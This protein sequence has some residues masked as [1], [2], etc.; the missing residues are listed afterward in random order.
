MKVTVSASGHPAANN[1]RVRCLSIDAAEAQQG[2]GEGIR[3]TFETIA[4]DTKGTKSYRTIS[5][6]ITPSNAAGQFVAQALGL[7]TLPLN[8][9][10]DLDDLIGGTF[11]A[12][13]VQSPKGSGTRV[14]SL[15]PLAAAA[16]PKA[17]PAVAQPE[18]DIDIPF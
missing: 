6:K 18:G 9:D 15:T 5:A 14:E 10:V 16:T 4:G 8:A 11:V 3:F 2:F 12:N 1:V 17:K 13:I 7:E